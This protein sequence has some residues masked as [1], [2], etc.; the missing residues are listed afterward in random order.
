MY[1]NTSLSAHQEMHTVAWVFAGVFVFLSVP[2]AL[3]A[4]MNHLNHWN[5]PE[6]QVY[7]GFYMLRHYG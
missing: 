7:Y 2:T 6:L 5:K 3:W 4:I 1:P